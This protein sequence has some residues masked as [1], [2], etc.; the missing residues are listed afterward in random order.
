MM[1]FFQNICSKTNELIELI[2]FCRSLKTSKQSVVIANQKSAKEDTID[3]GEG[4]D[5]TKLENLFNPESRD[6]KRRDAPVDTDEKEET[7]SEETLQFPDAQGVSTQ[8][9]SDSLPTSSIVD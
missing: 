1:N 3:A 8:N 2:Y 4:N 5:G 9:I 6:R 7:D